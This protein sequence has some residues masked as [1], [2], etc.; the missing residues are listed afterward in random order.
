MTTTASF[1]ADGNITLTDERSNLLEINGKASFTSIS[2]SQIDVG[3]NSDGTP[4]AGSTRFGSLQFNTAGAVR[5]H[6]DL[7]GSDGTL[8][9]MSNTAG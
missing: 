8:L 4:S 3:V 6:E 1:V 9:S 5:I 7:G 2:G